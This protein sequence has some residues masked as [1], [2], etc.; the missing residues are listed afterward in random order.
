MNP[1]IVILQCIT[2]GFFLVA[3]GVIIVPWVDYF[4]LQ[5]LNPFQWV[6]SYFDWCQKKQK[7]LRERS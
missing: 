3:F 7:E 5:R 6:I 2:A 4:L 1:A